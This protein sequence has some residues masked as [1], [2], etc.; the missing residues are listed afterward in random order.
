MKTPFRKTVTAIAM[1]TLLFISLPSNATLI[2]GV[3]A[4]TQFDGYV[5]SLGDTFEN[6]DGFSNSSQTHL[7]TQIAGLTFVNTLTRFGST[8]PAGTGVVVICNPGAPYYFNFPCSSPDHMIGGVRAGS[9]LVTDGQSRYE[10]NFSTPQL[11]AGVV[12]HFST[13][14]LTRFFSGATLLA[15]HRNTENREFVG[16]IADTDLITRIEM[17]GLVHPP[18]GSYQVGYV[19]E[20]YYGNRPEGVIP[21]PAT[22]ALMSLGLAGLGFARRKKA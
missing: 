2:Y 9:P 18:S 6:F 10:I 8:P 21:E 22:L 20:L 1:P 11:R 16:F 14:S 17:D 13:W 15:E 4:Q 12:R 19:D 3:A 5:S 7:T